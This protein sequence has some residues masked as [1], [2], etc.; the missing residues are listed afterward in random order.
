MSL[1]SS[2]TLQSMMTAISGLYRF[3]VLH[4]LVGGDVISLLFEV[5]TSRALSAHCELAAAARG[6][7]AVALRQPVRHNHR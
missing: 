3:G 4:E 7:A 2:P 6:S 1:T 5:P